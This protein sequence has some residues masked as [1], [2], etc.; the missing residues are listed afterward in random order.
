M[1][2]FP[3]P[4]SFPWSKRRCTMF[5]IVLHFLL[6]CLDCTM[7]TTC[8]LMT[9]WTAGGECSV[10][11]AFSCH[12]KVHGV[13]GEV[14]VVAC[15]VAQLTRSQFITVFCHGCDCRLQCDSGFWENMKSLK[16]SI[17]S[18]IVD[19]CYTMRYTSG[20]QERGESRSELWTI[21]CDYG[22]RVTMTTE[23]RGQ[24]VNDIL[25]GGGVWKS[26]FRPLEIIVC[27][28]W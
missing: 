5:S 17:S 23:D 4:H 9:R 22:L 26:K 2:R 12:R 18:W 25:R 11:C 14:E 10:W 15:G 27:R 1:V 19:W 7:S 16:G 21:I 3:Y 6:L 20:V 28:V 24:K 13:R 8:P